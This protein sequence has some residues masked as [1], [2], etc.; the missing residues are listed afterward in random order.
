MDGQGL[1]W[2]GIWGWVGLRQ[3]VVIGLDWVQVA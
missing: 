1:G 3:W 2:M